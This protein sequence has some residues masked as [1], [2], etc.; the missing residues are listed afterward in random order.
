M[1]SPARVHFKKDQTLRL[2]KLPGG[3]FDEGLSRFDTAVA[4]YGATERWEE[5]VNS[6]Y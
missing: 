6:R 3:A 2:N 5:G 1:L 4:V